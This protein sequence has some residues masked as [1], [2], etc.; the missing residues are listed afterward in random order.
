MIQ[1]IRHHVTDCAITPARMSI[2]RECHCFVINKGGWV[3]EVIQ[4]PGLSLSN[5]T[6]V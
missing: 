3:L 4:G 2:P 1:A 6:S 5:G